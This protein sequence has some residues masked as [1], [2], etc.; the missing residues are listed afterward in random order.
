MC[1]ST[2]I[3]NWFLIEWSKSLWKPSTKSQESQVHSPRSPSAS[4]QRL[5]GIR[6]HPRWSCSQKSL[7]VAIDIAFH[8]TKYSCILRQV[9]YILF[10]GREFALHSS[11]TTIFR[12]KETYTHT[13]IHTHTKKIQLLWTYETWRQYGRYKVLHHKPFSMRITLLLEG[14]WLWL[15]AQVDLSGMN[16]WEVSAWNYCKT[17]DLTSPIFKDFTTLRLFLVGHSSI[18]PFLLASCLFS[19][20]SAI[21]FV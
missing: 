13:H 1:A 5:V 17:R 3:H 18:E 15:F 14:Y 4:R 20:Q 12:R 10:L 19:F 11:K 7:C 8:I 9:F 21:F 16:I 6:N 2:S